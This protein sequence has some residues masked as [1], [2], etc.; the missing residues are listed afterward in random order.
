MV[1]DV[2]DTSHDVIYKPRD[3]MRRDIGV[4]TN[5]DVAYYPCIPEGNGIS[6]VFCVLCGVHDGKR[7]RKVNSRK[8]DI[9]SMLRRYVHLNIA[10]H[11]GSKICRNCFHKMQTIDSKII[12]LKE[13]SDKVTPGDPN[14]SFFNKGL[15][16]YPPRRNPTEAEQETSAENLPQGTSISSSSIVSGVKRENDF[17]TSPDLPENIFQPSF[18]GL[19]TS[20]FEAEE[21]AV[22]RQVQD[23]IATADAVETEETMETIQRYK[24][25]R[26]FIVSIT[27][28]QI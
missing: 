3:V 19:D 11:R 16:L 5:T 18:E 23:A 7:L 22:S 4:G 15:Q 1:P 8:E 17:E 21:P 6:E 24:T 14:L 13:L 9:P 2:T 12:Q 27:K 10:F 25:K 26:W 28:L 20:G